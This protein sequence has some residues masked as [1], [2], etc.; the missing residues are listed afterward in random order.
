MLPDEIISQILSP[1]LTV[2]DEL[3]SDTSD[4]SPFAQYSPSTSAYLV[5]CKDWLR[6]ATPLL[7]KV[8]VLRSKGQADALE[9]VLRDNPEFGLFIRKLRVEGGYGMAM[10]T[11]LES[12]KN[13]TDI[14]LCL[15]IWSSDN[16]RGLCKGLPLINPHRVIV[17]DPIVAKRPVKNQHQ[18]ALNNALFQC[19]RAWSNLRTF[20]FPYPS[21]VPWRW[22]NR[23]MEVAQ[24]L[25]ESRI[26][27][28]VIISK[29][30]DTLPQHF[31]ILLKIPALH[32]VQFQSPFVKANFYHRRITETID[33]DA[34][35]KALVQY[36]IHDGSSKPVQDDDTM[37]D[38]A[39]SLNPLFV[40]MESAP[41]E[42]QDTV[43]D[44]VMFFAMSTSEEK[45]KSSR[46]SVLL[47]SKRFNRL[48]L[49]HIYHRICLRWP[50]AP[51]VSQQMQRQ[52]QLGSFIRFLEIPFA[53]TDDVAHR[54]LSSATRIEKFSGTISAEHFELLARTAGSTLRE[55]SSTI[56]PS[57]ATTSI[58]AVFR[59]FRELRVFELS[60]TSVKFAPPT[61]QDDLDQLH[62]L[63]MGRENPTFLD[64]ISNMRLASLHTFSLLSC[65][66]DVQPLFAFL[67]VHGK[68]LLHA[69]FGD[70]FADDWIERA[71]LFDTC[72][73]LVDVKFTEDFD[74]A[75]L[76]C[77]TP[78]ESL[79][80]IVFGDDVDI[81]DA[82]ALDFT[83][84][85]ALREIQCNH[86]KWPTT[87]RAISKSAWVSL[88][89]SLL[90][91][92]VKLTDF[93][94]K[95]WTPRVKS[96][97]KSRKR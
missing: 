12:A 75:D 55:V 34:R 95:H 57:S 58:S 47:V 51:S 11:I 30:Y 88:A 96:T 7:Y 49:P 97:R 60:A 50:N 26:L 70:I 71:R 68:Y 84:F 18:A 6:V 72:T 74:L 22:S 79:A 21:S 10:H 28:T 87:E 29:T 62:T 1:A 37:P 4:V 36:T 64:A 80:K 5:V 20:V 81:E 44:R 65:R 76:V 31:D 90:E 33:S 32:T 92:N 83:M 45:T 59:H 67:R 61:S 91:K 19:I 54:I 63:C 66:G 3:F 8:V 73:S 25:I 14:S 78:H 23:V 13:I 89:E 38:I 2:S 41:V 15:S 40:P 85:P 39:P 53:S 56:L 86:L 35:L 46:L 77:T 42:T 93:N 9:Q 24:A 82:H 69:T 27:S 48:A 94:G 43:W 52:P 16:S 17:V